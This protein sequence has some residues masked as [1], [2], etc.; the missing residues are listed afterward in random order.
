M[1]DSEIKSFKAYLKLE[2]ALSENSVDAYLRD[3]QKLAKYSSESLGKKGLT[4]LELADFESFVK[5]LVEIGLAPYSQARIISGIKAFFKYLHLEEIISINPTELL[6]APKL[7]RKLPDTLS[8]S[9]IEQMLANIDRSKP[10]G[11]R[12]RAIIE[13]LYAC[14]LRVSELVNLLL[15]NLFF[16]EGFIRVI[17]KGNKERLVPIH[18]NAIDS[19]TNYIENVR[20]HMPVVDGHRDFV[21][22]N[23]RGKKLSRVMIFYVIRDLAAVSGIR[24][25]IS[26][27]TLRHSFATELVEHGA[28]LRAVQEMLGHSSITTTEIYTHLDRKYLTETVMKYHPLYNQPQ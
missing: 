15:S 10:T 6:E 5:Q 13:T 16:D 1:W 21:F 28:D 17:G 2:R 12:N 3:V 7:G 19:V 18:D 24:K 22:L 20:V 25:N 11:E 26:P 9:E 23:N 8:N 14:G 4:Q 27:H